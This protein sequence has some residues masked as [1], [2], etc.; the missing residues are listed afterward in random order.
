[1][2]SL[3]QW[4]VEEVEDENLWQEDDDGSYTSNDSVYQH[5]F[6]WSGGHTGAD[7]IAQPS[8][9]VLDPSLRNL[10]QHKGGRKHDEEQQDEDRETYVFVGK[11]AIDEVSYLI[12]VFDL[13]GFIA[14]F[15]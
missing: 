14:C 12:G 15:L 2:G 6:H 10:T 9:S 11:Y 5:V 7:D 8:H 3:H 13:T 1:V 4:C